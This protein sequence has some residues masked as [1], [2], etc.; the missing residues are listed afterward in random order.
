MAKRPRIGI[1]TRLEIETRRFY[2]GRDYSDA[3][4]AHGGVP[5]LINLIPK[6]GYIN[7]VLDDLDGI[8]LPGSD[9]DIDPHYFGEQPHAN[10]GSVVTEKDETDL[11][12]LAEAEKRGLPLFAICFGMQALNVSRGGSL[13]QDIESQVDGHIKHQQGVPRARNSHHL[14]VEEDSLLGQMS[15]GNGNVRVNSH[16]HQ[17]VGRLGNDLKATARASDGIVE[18]IEDTRDGRFVVGVQWHPEL[19]WADD[20]LSGKLFETFLRACV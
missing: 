6:H 20:R 13:I 9:S 7:G 10:L 11:L 4:E 14:V 5:V 15:A 18:C 8:L 2:L 3:V 12:V 19:S 17:A 16:H 1:T